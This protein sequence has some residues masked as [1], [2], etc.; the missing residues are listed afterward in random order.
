MPRRLAFAERLR[1]GY[2]AGGDLARRWEA[3]LPELRA[4]YPNVTIAPQVGLV[5]LGRDADS[6]LW[7]F[8]HLASGELPQRDGAGRFELTE[9]SGLVFVLLPG[10]RFTMGAQSSDRSGPN[11][12]PHAYADETPHEVTLSPFL[13]SKYEM[14]Q[15][16]WTRFVRPNP[17]HYQPPNGL[18]PSLLHPVEQV[19][20]IEC[21]ALCERMGLALP[22]EAQ[23]EYATRGGTS[24][25]WW[26]GDDRDSLVGAVNIADQAARRG[27]AVWTDISKWPELDD[28]YV[29]HAPVDTYRANPFGLHNVHGNVSEWCLDGYYED[30]YRRG[31]VLDPVA[32]PTGSW[33]RTNRGGCLR[34]SAEVT[35]S[36]NRAQLNPDY[37]DNTIGLRPARPWRVP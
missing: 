10:G 13:L 24:S 16:Q 31:P 21:V 15:G 7:E 33:T 11:H 14:T 28:G 17:S 6:G 20:W 1:D 37:A 35:R 25:V 9:E 26:T 32:D 34:N 12:D 36:A 30:Y 19:S 23:W 22:T 27:G 5:P 8:G 29:V 3:V 18:A 4:A 2:R